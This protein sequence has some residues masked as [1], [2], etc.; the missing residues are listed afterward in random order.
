M[1]KKVSQLK[2]FKESLASITK[3]SRPIRG[4]KRNSFLNS[5][6]RIAKL[7]QIE[8]ESNLFD[9]KVTRQKHVVFGMKI[10]GKTGKPGTT[11][12]AGESNVTLTDFVRANRV[13]KEK[14]FTSK[15]QFEEWPHNR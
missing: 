7:K 11:K 2:R 14:A 3:E 8:E 15:G 6:E 13:E 9:T 1:A 5:S 12:E 4:K 10:K